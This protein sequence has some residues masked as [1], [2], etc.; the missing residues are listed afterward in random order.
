MAS[1]P[2]KHGAD[3]R[4]AFGTTSTGVH[5]DFRTSPD[6]RTAEEIRREAW[7]RA[8]APQKVRKRK[9]VSART[10]KRRLNMA[11][12]A[13]VIVGA[14]VF[15][16]LYGDTLWSD[17]PVPLQPALAVPAASVQPAPVA[18][19]VPAENA[20]DAVPVVP[21]I[22]PTD[23][24]SEV[25]TDEPSVEPDAGAVPEPVESRVWVSA[26]GSRYHAKADCSN[27]KDPAQLSLEEAKAR[28]LTPCKR[29]DPPE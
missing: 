11:L 7:A 28:G 27:M 6:D 16:V 19:A 17:P 10:K 13:V 5:F 20:A 21:E 2:G 22:K 15:G 24:F 18:S 4:K 8:V 9:K 23:G 3:Q 14:A 1:K 26:S 25:K 29:C 12:T